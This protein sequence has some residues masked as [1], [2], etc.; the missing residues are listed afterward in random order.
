MM[1][2]RS[3]LL[4]LMCLLSG[5]AVQPACTKKK[6]EE[7]SS[8]KS[9]PSGPKI[10]Y[11][12]RRSEEKSLDPVK[13]FDEASRQHS[14]N[15]FD[16]LLE[17][18]YLKRPY[19][20]APSLLT[21]MPEKQADGV[22]YLFALKQG[23]KFH[24]HAI[25][26][27]GK[28]REMVTDDVIYSLKRFADANTN[29][30]SYTLIQGLVV[31]MD[32]FRELARKEG[33]T[34]NY[35]KNEISGLKKVDNYQFTITFTRDSPLNFYPLA[36]E[37]TSVVPREAIEK[38]GD[39]FDKNPIGTGPFYLKSYA[40]RGTTVLARNPNYH[41]TYPTEGAAGDQEAGLL[42]SAGKKLPLVDEVHLPLIEESQPQML[43]FKKG[44]VAWVAI[45]RD[46]YVAMVDR[47][48]TTDGTKKFKLK[49]EFEKQ[50]A[51]YYVPSLATNFMRFGMKDPVVG[52]NKALR[53][54]IAYAMN[55]DG[56]I[57][58]MYNG[59]GVRSE[60]MIP[61]EIAGSGRETGST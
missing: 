36:F 21:K 24:D 28:G 51:L 43:K 19:E 15:I 17:Y 49:P 33:K 27:G 1:K 46:D 32:E 40:R 45:S 23:V 54:A 42:Q 35:D 16:V 59:R 25:F 41:G 7:T 11:H 18:S 22:T 20:L 3:R 38:F 53:Q 55:A 12:Y 4:A 37:G 14:R 44:E 2:I 30:L 8:V 13:A 39:D 6:P 9:S 52:S 34:F 47:V 48:P 60:S 10:L 56:F 50:Y 26:P 58:M 5:M 29:R 61:N 31:G 57:E